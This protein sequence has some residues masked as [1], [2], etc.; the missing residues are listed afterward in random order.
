LVWDYLYVS[1]KIA[2]IGDASGF[3]KPWSGGGIVWALD[4]CREYAKD[5]RNIRKVTKKLLVKYL[6]HYCISSLIFKAS[7]TAPHILPSKLRVDYDY[8]MKIFPFEKENTH[9]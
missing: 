2:L 8:P 6:F 5:V 1:E 3:V 4:F 9:A 7:I